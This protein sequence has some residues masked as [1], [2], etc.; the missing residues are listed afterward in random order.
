MIAAGLMAADRPA[1]RQMNQQA[2]IRQGVRS[3]ELNRAEAR[4]LQAREAALHRQIVRDR[5]DGGGLTAAER[6]RIEQRQDALSRAIARE[7]HDAQHR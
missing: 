1:Q 5:I 6:L 2:R 4:T 7:K 3:G